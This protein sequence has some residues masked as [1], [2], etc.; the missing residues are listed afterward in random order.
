MYFKI[1]DVVIDE[2]AQNLNPYATL[3]LVFFIRASNKKGENWYGHA[4]I[5]KKLNMSKRS[6]VRACQILENDGYILV[7][8]KHGL[9]NRYRLAWVVP[10][11]HTPVPHSHTV[12]T[13][14]HTKEY[15]F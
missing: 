13:N 15:P 12:V 5:A 7:N 3:V 4:T 14:S 8:R 9:S 2:W 6:V 10:H 11:S 1:A